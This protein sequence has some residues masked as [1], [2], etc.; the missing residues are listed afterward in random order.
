MQSKL[1]GNEKAELIIGKGEKP[2]SQMKFNE[3]RY[4]KN[5]QKQI[6]ISKATELNK[7]YKIEHF[8]SKKDTPHNPIGE[9]SSTPLETS[10]N[11]SQ[12]NQSSKNES[13]TNQAIPPQP[14]NSNMQALPLN[15]D[16]V[17]NN[18]FS[19]PV[20]SYQQPI[21]LT[22]A[23]QLFLSFS[24]IGTMLVASNNTTNSLQEERQP[25]SCDG[26]R[27]NQ[28]RKGPSQWQ[29]QFFVPF[30]QIVQDNIFNDSIKL[31]P[32]TEKVKH[33]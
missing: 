16:N 24:P 4:F 9:Q 21:Y 26:T 31:T 1:Y 13:S 15:I 14:S 29:P 18:Q 25:N 22:Y 2:E 23:P 28:E 7:N 30:P 27:T 6:N 12:S 3:H 32:S 5:R 33:Q 20:G 11:S 19:S 17:G 8:F 10:S